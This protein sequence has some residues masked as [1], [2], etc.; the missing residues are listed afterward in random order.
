MKLEK[1]NKRAK[2]TIYW[3]K[4][5]KNMSSEGNLLERNER[6][7]TQCFICSYHVKYLIFKEEA[8]K[9]KARLFLS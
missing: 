2:L 7:Q 1:E 4:C 9:E 6:E 8:Q 5:S 3:V